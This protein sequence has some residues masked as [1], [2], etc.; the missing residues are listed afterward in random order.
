MTLLN[1]SFAEASEPDSAR[2]KVIVSRGTNVVELDAV[3]MHVCTHVRLSMLPLTAP[4]SRNDAIDSLAEAHNPVVGSTIVGHGLMYESLYRQLPLHHNL[5]ILHS[6]DCYRY[7]VASSVEVEF[8]SESF[9]VSG[10]IIVLSVSS[11]N[12]I[13]LMYSYDMLERYVDH[14]YTSKSFTLVNRYT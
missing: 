8:D 1:V 9:E 11:A 14:V 6:D 13:A 2:A 10:K 3:V 7:I 5:I 12:A 4:L